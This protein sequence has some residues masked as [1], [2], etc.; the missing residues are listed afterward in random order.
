MSNSPKARITRGPPPD[1]QIKRHRYG[2][3][4]PHLR[5]GARTPSN[6]THA[7][8]NWKLIT[9]ILAKR[10]TSISSTTT[11]SLLLD[12]A[13]RRNPTIG[14][15]SLKKPQASGSLTRAAKWIT[16]CR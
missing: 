15:Q 11:F 8:E 5:E 16:E 4:L 2:E 6:I 14:R 13:T 1:K 12:I 9:S 10:R 7:L 3:V